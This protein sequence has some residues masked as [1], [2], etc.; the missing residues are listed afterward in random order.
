LEA[1]ETPCHAEAAMD[2]R[3]MPPAVRR[4]LRQSMPHFAVYQMPY[5]FISHRL[6]RTAISIDALIVNITFN[7]YDSD[8]FDFA[9]SIIH[10]RVLKRACHQSTSSR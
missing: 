2:Y 4:N 7:G 3:V 8:A 6:Y 1:L 9:T 10:S 5:H